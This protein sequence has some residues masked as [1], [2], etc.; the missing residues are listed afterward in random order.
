MLENTYD[1]TNDKI[2]EVLLSMTKKNKKLNNFINRFFKKHNNECLSLIFDPEMKWDVECYGKGAECSEIAL[3]TDFEYTICDDPSEVE[4]DGW[5]MFQMPRIFSDYF[6]D[7]NWKSVT[8]DDGH[9]LLL[10]DE[11]DHIA[12]NIVHF[13]NMEDGMVDLHILTWNAKFYNKKY[14]NLQD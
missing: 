1:F 4:N 5:E 14:D 8:L 7:F 12:F 6:T 13:D 9:I 11:D 3:K 10:T 2:K